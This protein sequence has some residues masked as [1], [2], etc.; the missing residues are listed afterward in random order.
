MKKLQ[1]LVIA[2]S[3]LLSGLAIGQIEKPK[4]KS[5]WTIGAILINEWNWNN[6]L[7]EHHV[8]Q[9]YF[10]GITVK[11]HFAGFTA[12][13][14]IEYITIN[15][16]PGKRIDFGSN[17]IGYFNEG[18]LR[19]GIEKGFVIKNKV[20]PY[21]AMDAAG[22]KSYSDFT[23]ETIGCLP[24]VSK[25]QISRGFGFGLMPALGI[26][27]K[28]TK[29]VSLSFETRARFLFNRWGTKTLYAYDDSE[30]EDQI[31]KDFDVTI[32]RIGGLTL[33]VRF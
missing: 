13:A 27:Y 17:R 12:R 20:R 29:T 15:N 1:I 6:Y 18:I 16:S 25:Q 5:K 3:L 30:W 28:F 14:G 8:S 10:D 33:N 24:S 23:S 22:I 21:I 9:N 7:G 11:R 4:T 2:I 31:Y 26:E 32:N 19:L